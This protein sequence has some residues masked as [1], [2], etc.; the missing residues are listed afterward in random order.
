[1]NAIGVL[2]VVIVEVNNWGDSIGFLGPAMFLYGI[3]F[4][5]DGL[6]RKGGWNSESGNCVLLAQIV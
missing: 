1:L 5:V 3:Y 4:L 6:T 2:V